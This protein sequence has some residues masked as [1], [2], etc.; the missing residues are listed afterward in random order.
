MK[1]T[2][3]SRFPRADTPAWKRTLGEE[4]LSCGYELAL[5]YSRERARRP[6]QRGLSGVRV[7]SIRPVTYSVATDQRRRA[8]RRRSR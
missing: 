3:V 4:A 5:V 2:L 7:R 1:I 8:P 6:R